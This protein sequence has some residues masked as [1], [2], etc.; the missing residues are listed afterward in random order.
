MADLEKQVQEGSSTI[1]PQVTHVDG[2]N[3]NVVYMTK[4]S[5]KFA[6]PTPLGLFSFASTTLILSLYNLRTRGITVPN[7][8]VGQAIGVGGLGQ[9]LAG[10]GEFF[11]G[12]MFGCTAFTSFG[13]FW[14]AWAII[15]IPDS[16]IAAAYAVNEF[17]A[18]QKNDAIAIWLITWFIVTFLLFLASF[19][20]NVATSLVFFFL[21]LTFIL[22][23]AGDF[24][25]RVGVIK[26]G[27]AMGVVTAF[28]AFYTGCAVLYTP[29]A[30]YFRL[31]VLDLPK[32]RN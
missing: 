21:F 7:A 26:A 5:T 1:S 12:N 28:Q 6:N 2:H 14:L 17:T 4:P 19:R 20:S 32:R 16:G 9:I 27:G 31:P 24:T 10:I 29:E 30:T 13:G 23:A 8:V 25:E 18:Q 22:L 11:V 3:P 15:Q